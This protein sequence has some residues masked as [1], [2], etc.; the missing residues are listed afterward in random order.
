MLEKIGKWK[1]IKQS[2]NCEIK[3][4]DPLKV[5]MKDRVEKEYNIPPVDLHE[6]K[7]DKKVN[8]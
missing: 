5:W 2:G 3:N 4:S 7:G 6:T 8:R 1:K